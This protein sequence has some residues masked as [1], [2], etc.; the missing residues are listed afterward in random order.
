MS[1]Q[2]ILFSATNGTTGYELWVTDGTSANTSLLK[3][4][5]GGV[6]ASSPQ[7]FFGLGNGRVV[8]QATTAAGGAELWISDGTSAGTSMVRDINSG[9]ASSNPTL[10]ATLSNGRAIFSATDGTHGV[11]LWATNGT[12]VGTYQLQDINGG[13]GDSTP[14]SAIVL[15]NGKAL[16]RATDATHGTEL[17]ITDG[18]SAG[19][20]IVMDIDAG[21]ASSTPAQ[22][23]LLPNG[24]MVFRATD[25]T[26][27]AE[28]WITDGT[29]TGTSMVRDINTATTG[30]IDGYPN[31]MASLGNG[32]VLFRAYTAATG[33]ELWVTD[34]T[35]AGTSILKDIRSGTG[36]GNP[37]T[38]T[39]VPNGS[40][41]PIAVFKA[42]DL[43]HGIELWV[44]DGT[45]AGTS[46][47]KDINTTGSISASSAP[48]TFTSLGGSSGKVLFVADNGSQGYELWVTNG[49]SGGTSLV[50]DI[51]PGAGSSN[52]TNFT[53]IGGGKALFQADDGSHGPELWITDGTSAGTSIVK[54]INGTGTAGSNPSSIVAF[55]V[56]S[57]PVI[58][59]FTPDTGTAGD[60]ITNTGAL[61]VNGTA[62]AAD[63]VTLFDGATQIGTAAANAGGAWSISPG[64][65]LAEGSHTLSAF[66]TEGGLISPTSASFTIQVDTTAPLAPAITAISSD[67]GSNGSDGITKTASQ[68]VSGTAEIGST[69]ALSNGGTLVSTVVTD[70]TGHWSSGTITLASGSNT[71]T[72][73]AT[74]VAGNVSSAGTFV[75]VLDSAVPA[76]P[77]ITG[78]SNDTGSSASDG[79][80]TTALQVV[81][82]TAEAG[83]TLNLSNGGTLVSTVVTDGAG[84]WSSGRSRWRLAATH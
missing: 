51:N 3:D 2:T 6:L 36:S 43:T 9:A 16:F 61:T 5:N 20:S 41:T 49:T 8:F 35:S 57:A 84:H 71:L 60:G 47:L 78:I 59:G 67:T 74:D 69:L 76:P 37:N 81:R 34:G 72:A 28:L 53:A 56:T 63:I 44:S 12:S 50:R 13:T 23:V 25:A 17:W 79:I 64:A 18:T 26:H 68:T 39:L 65:A 48:Q 75:A 31:F 10:L 80:T 55:V 70:G 30:N 62:T 19:T 38:P 15:G 11:E 54:D 14:A 42:N 4:I 73:T 40:S 1:Q 52:P 45:S 77:S 24:K 33:V 83:S 32:K 22:M 21:T 46:L 29:S 66:A 82:G 58:T 7:G 27:G